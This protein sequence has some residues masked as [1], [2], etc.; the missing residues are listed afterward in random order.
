MA[1]E[2]IL[3][4]LDEEADRILDAFEERTGLDGEDDGDKR[5]YPIEGTEHEIDVVQTLTDIDEDWTEHVG[6]QDPG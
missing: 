1:D 6:V 3:T 4:K 5:T 2:I